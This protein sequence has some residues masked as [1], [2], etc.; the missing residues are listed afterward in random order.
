V[1]LHLGH[2]GIV[3]VV[4]VRTN[5]S[6][7]KRAITKVCPLPIEGISLRKNGVA[8]HVDPNDSK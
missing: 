5:N 3:R 4:S 2:D 1:E 8:H 6:V 7:V